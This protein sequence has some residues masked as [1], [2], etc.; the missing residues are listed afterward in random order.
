M[1]DGNENLKPETS[2]QFS[3]GIRLEPSPTLSMC[4]GL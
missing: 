4:L 1:S 2:K 3:V